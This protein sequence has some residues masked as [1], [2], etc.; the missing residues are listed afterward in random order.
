MNDIAGS[1]APPARMADYFE[2]G[3]RAE[4]E[5]LFTRALSLAARRWG[6]HVETSLQAMT[7]QSRPRWQTLFVLSMAEPPVTTSTLATRLAIRWPSLIRTLNGLEADGLVRRT[8]NPDDRRSRWIAITPAGLAVLHSVMP[9][10][11]E[12]RADA[13]DTLDDADMQAATRVLRVLIDGLAS[14]PLR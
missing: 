8:T 11:T 13:L 4:T 5:F 10:L 3:S 14:A 7:G 9:V 12:V 2:P 1:P 6:Q